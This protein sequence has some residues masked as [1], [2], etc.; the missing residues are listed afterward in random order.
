MSRFQA[1]CEVNAKCNEA[2]SNCDHCR[3]Q[4]KF[5]EMK[6]NEKPNN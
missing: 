3:E 1:Q 6:Y 4:I 5:K 2:Y